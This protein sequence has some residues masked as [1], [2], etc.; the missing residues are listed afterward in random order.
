[1]GGPRPIAYTP[2]GELTVFVFFGPVAVIGSDWAL[3]GGVGAW[4][5]PAAAAI[6]SLAAAA[7]ALNNH[8]DRA[9]DAE[10]GRRTFAV[11]FGPRASAG[12]YGALLL[13]PFALWAAAA[14]AAAGRRCCCG[15]CWR[16]PPGG[17]GAISGVVRRARPS[18]VAVPRSFRMVGAFAVLLAAGA[19]LARW[20]A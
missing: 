20:T 18:T 14:L 2:F 9:H 11:C 10:A 16:L 4:T 12:L 17:C 3:S 15:G 8:R 5:V 6:G 1:M 7:L 19:V 13:G